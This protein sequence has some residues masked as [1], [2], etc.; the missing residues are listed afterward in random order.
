MATYDI[1]GTVKLV[2]DLQTFPSGFSK[3]EFVIVTDD[4]YPQEVKF[5]AL[6]DKA[7]LIDNVREGD[8]VAVKFAVNG[9]EYNGKYYVSLVALGVENQSDQ[10][11]TE[12]TDAGDPVEEELGF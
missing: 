1:T 9:R 7:T 8:T 2:D 3:R 5:E 4:K 10:P 11:Y 6:K 12:P